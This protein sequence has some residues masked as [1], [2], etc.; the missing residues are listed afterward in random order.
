MSH[1]RRLLTYAL[2]GPLPAVF[3]ALWLSWSADWPARI[4]FTLTL[5]ILASWL[6]C[7]GA[8]HARHTRSLQTA[9]NL[10]SAMQ[11][12]D[13]SI[14]A[15][16][17]KREDALG[18]LYA[19]INTLG[20]LL[21]QQRLSAMEATAL[22]ETVMQAIDV[23][24]FA[25]DQNGFL[26]LVNPAA[27]RILNLTTEE[28]LGLHADELGLG[29]CLAGD[30]VRMLSA[31][32]FAAAGRWGLRRT[33]F[34]E[35]GRPHSLVV[36]A[37][38]SRPLRAEEA[39]AW[40]RLVRVLGH[41]LNNSLAPIKSISGSLG[42]LLRRS[43][44]PNDWEQ[45]LQDGLEII[46]TRAEGLAR[47]M[48]AYSTLARLPRPSLARTELK[49]LLLRIAALDTRLPVQITEGPTVYLACDAPQL[50]QA[51][52]NLL[53]NAVDANLSTLTTG[54]AAHDP[55]SERAPSTWPPVSIT[56]TLTKEQVDI[57]IADRGPGL[58]SSA[59]LFVPFFTT[60]P[61]G[62]GIG[63][64]LSRQIIENHEGSLTLS[65]LAAPASG[66]IANIRL[67]I[68][69]ADPV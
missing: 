36:L 29:D 27:Q 44:R 46:S 20:A 14:R 42:T 48:Q 62:S 28:L 60:K 55:N 50:E 21:S 38:L 18:E 43:P 24:V 67:P 37:D 1:S 69:P 32:P 9:A 54:D 23:A 19:E 7:V 12:G 3:V 22:V 4:P 11:E 68:L 30:P 17:L 6:G 41:E 58:S 66:C 51:F 39:L 35:Q 64:V 45:D 13:F 34:R 8:F 2:L 26:R 15:H 65:N 31:T 63:L 40:Q 49:P 16:R 53:R 33:S 57:H 52:I 47:F 5:I 61:N 25:F 10:L 59:N 56:W